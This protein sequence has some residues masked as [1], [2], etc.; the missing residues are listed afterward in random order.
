MGAC[1]SRHTQIHI[2][3]TP[4]IEEPLQC[5]LT[6]S[7]YNV[8]ESWLCE[9]DDAKKPAVLRIVLFQEQIEKAKSFKVTNLERENKGIMTAKLEEA[10]AIFVA[11]WRNRDVNDL[12]TYDEPRHCPSP[13]ITPHYTRG[14]DIK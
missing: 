3:P 4:R 5:I 2:E 14:V 12:V 6:D 10:H 7:Q 1:H 9:G 13:G 11:T 8:F